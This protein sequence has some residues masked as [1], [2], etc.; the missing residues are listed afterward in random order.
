MR[1][2]KTCG[3]CAAEAAS[4][5]NE[6]KT[7]TSAAGRRGANTVRGGNNLLGDPLHKED[8]EPLDDV[9]GSPEVPEYAGG[10]YSDHDHMDSEYVHSED[11]G[12]EAY[13]EDDIAGL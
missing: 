9:Y 11:Y 10:V 13:G 4:E 1:C 5:K 7:T 8:P 12:E 6:T 2:P 3:L